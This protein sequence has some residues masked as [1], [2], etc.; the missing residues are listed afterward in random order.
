MGT[1][2]DVELNKEWQRIC[3]PKKPTHFSRSHLIFIQ[4]NKCLGSTLMPTEICFDQPYSFWAPKP[5]PKGTILFLVMIDG[6]KI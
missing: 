5:A 4:H 6:M 2:L 1:F 3:E